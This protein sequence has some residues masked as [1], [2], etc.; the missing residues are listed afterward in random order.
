MTYQDFTRLIGGARDCET[1]D[2]YIT[3]AGGSVPADDIDEVLRILHYCWT[4]A[5]TQT[6]S[7]VRSLTGLSQAAFAREYNI[8]RRTIENWDSGTNAAPGYVSDLLAFAA[9]NTE[10]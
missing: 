4:Y 8:P 2:Q 1:E 9:L 10:A 6:P 3:E 5:Q 7:T